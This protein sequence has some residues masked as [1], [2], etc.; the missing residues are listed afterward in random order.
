MKTNDTTTIK[1]HKLPTSTLKEIISLQEN[2]PESNIICRECYE[3]L[4]KRGKIE[5]KFETKNV[6]KTIK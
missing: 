2:T 1:L 3:E 4:L 6:K 5:P